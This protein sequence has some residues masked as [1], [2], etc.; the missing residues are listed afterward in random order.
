MLLPALAPERAREIVSRAGGVH[1]LVVGDAMLDKFIVGRVTRIS[2][3]APV[4]VVAFDHDMYR[5]GGAA[6]VA[7]NV[8]ALGGEAT[9]IAIT[10]RDETAATLAHA[11]REAGIAP[12]LVSDAGRPTTTKARV[13]TDRNQ[14][15]ARIDYENDAEI[16]GEI[17]DRI[18]GEIRKHAPRGSA[19][20]VSDYMKGCVT[21]QV[22]Q[23]AIAAAAERGT[24]VLVDPKIP[25]LDYYV[26]ATLVTP[27]H[28]EAEAATHRRV[29][30]EDEAR[31]A[32]RLFRERA[33]CRDV[34]MTRGD[35]GIWLLSS[36]LEGHLPAAAREVA[37]VTGAGDTVIATLAV[38]LAAGATLAEAARLANEA[39]GIVV[40]K[41]GP[42]TASTTELLAAIN[43]Q[44]SV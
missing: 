40:G 32:A 15:V 33:R 30:S 9:L 13:V 6:N 37:D 38:A 23:T 28:Y 7:C 17:E 16:S 10:G 1:I 5:I 20:I 8:V 14:Q 24:P 27:N 44:A 42:A 22:M 11:C 39:A 36:T 19:I 31:D 21:R 26:G 12:S 34:L 25:H 18:I 4:P 43:A 35:Q 41:F 2:P 29:R 3:E